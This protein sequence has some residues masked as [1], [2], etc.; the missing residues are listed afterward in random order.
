MLCAVAVAVF[1]GTGGQQRAVVEVDTWWVRWVRSGQVD[2][3]SSESIYGG[4]SW[5][6]LGCDKSTHAVDT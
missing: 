6:G 1:A 4:L 3:C 5:V 2:A